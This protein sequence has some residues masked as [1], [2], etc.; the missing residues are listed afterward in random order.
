MQAKSTR[1]LLFGPHAQGFQALSQVSV[2]RGFVRVPMP[3]LWPSPSSSSVH[4]AYEGSRRSSETVT[5]CANNLSRRYPFDGTV[6][7]RVD[8]FKR[9]THFSTPELRSGDKYE[10]IS[11]GTHTVFRILRD[12]DRLCEYGIVSTSGQNRQNSPNLP[13]HVEKAEGIALRSD[14]TGGSSKCH[15]SNNSTRSP[16]SEI[17]AVSAN[18]RGQ[19]GELQF[20]CEF[21]SQQLSRVGMVG[22]ESSPLE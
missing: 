16:Q 3:V 17:S 8:S 15:L 9:H 21:E 19:E 5:Y 11:S 14:K 4:Q 18:S 6:D 20:S 10:E 13:I 2:G 7:F 12:E 22:P 1:C